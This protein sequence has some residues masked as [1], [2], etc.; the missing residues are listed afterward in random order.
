MAILLSIIIILLSTNVI[1]TWP[2]SPSPAGTNKL[3]YVIIEFYNQ[4]LQKPS[5]VVGGMKEKGVGS[6]SLSL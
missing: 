6:I 4:Q 1:P 3:L 5:L 2:F